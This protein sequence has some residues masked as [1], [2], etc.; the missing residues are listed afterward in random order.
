MHAMVT[1]F[2]DMAKALDLADRNDLAELY[3][4]LGLAIAYDHQLQVAE[5]SITPTLRG[6]KKCVR[7]GT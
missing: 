7:G 6:T 2:G 3:E 1:Q 4:G 5:V